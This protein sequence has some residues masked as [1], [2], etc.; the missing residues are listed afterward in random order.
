[1]ADAPALL[2]DLYEFTMAAAYVAEGTAERSATF[3][4]FVRDLPPERGFL[5]A[6]GLDDALAWLEGLHFG[7]ADLEVLRATGVDFGG[8][9]LDWLGQA[10]FTGTVR[11]VPEGTVVFAGEPLLEVDAPLAVA[12]LAETFLLNQVTLQTTLATKCARCRL[13]AG[14]ATVVDFALRRTQGADAGMKVV[15]CARIAGIDATSNVAG[16]ARY[17]LPAAGT[18][19]HSYVQAHGDEEEEEAAFRVF[20]R[21]YGEQTVLLV[22]TYDTVR[23]VERAI[24]VAREMREQGVELRGVRLDS[25][26]LAELS[27]RT[28]ELLDEA[29]FP[30]MRILASGGLDEYEVERLR[31]AGAPIDAF[32]IG[33]G[34][35]V[36][37]DAPTLDSV[38]KLVQLDGRPLR[39]TSEGKATWPGRKQ[40]WRRAGFAGD[41]LGLAGEAAPPRAEPLLVEVMRDGRRTDPGATDLD[42]AAGR[43]RAALA[44][45]PEGVRRLRRADA[46]AVEPS[47]ALAEL[48]AG[49]GGS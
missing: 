26:D 31:A 44:A 4:L 28:R 7:P 11:A 40:V 22:D 24:A 29:G 36:S 1:M 32:G 18:M 42:A 8:E 19:A 21:R 2:T 10:R 39:K 13:A 27:R 34:M 37:R 6:A 14:D 30:G 35:G 41:V 49:P 48:T 17:G 33:T 47:E 20:A 43:C 25:G 12:Q 3:S 38:Y 46:Y 23:G 15:R 5:V 9:F 16:A 45:L